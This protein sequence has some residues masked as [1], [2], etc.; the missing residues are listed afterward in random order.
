MEI[1]ITNAYT[2]NLTRKYSY[3]NTHVLQCF[4]GRAAGFER[5][6]G[7]DGKRGKFVDVLSAFE[8]DRPPIGA[9]VADV[10]LQRR[11]FGVTRL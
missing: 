6:D 10:I 2:S 1:I 4:L 9:G 8:R 5:G 3:V 11:A 7:F